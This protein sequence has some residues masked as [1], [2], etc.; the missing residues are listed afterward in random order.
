[1][2]TIAYKDGVI[3][4][5]SRQCMGSLILDDDYDKKHVCDGNA[6]FFSG[7][8]CELEALVR[9]F[10]GESLEVRDQ[11]SALVYSNGTL[12]YCGMNKDSGFFSC[13]E[14]LAR[15]FVLGSGRD[16]ALTAMD[17]GA[18][19]REAV[20]MAIKR[21]SGSGGRVRTYKLKGFEG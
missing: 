2:T 17:M 19:A 21:D 4:Y 5:D 3:A 12:F 18:T 16:H 11:C 1:M 6:F 7:P 13:E 9:M 15:P 8:S 20:K 14:S 10:S